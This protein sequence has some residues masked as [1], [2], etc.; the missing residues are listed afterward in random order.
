MFRSSSLSIFSASSFISVFFKAINLLLF[1]VLSR[2]P[3]KALISWEAGVLGRSGRQR[4]FASVLHFF[5][6]LFSFTFQVSFFLLCNFDPRKKL[7]GRGLQL[8]R[9][10]SP[11]FPLA[12]TH[13]PF[14]LVYFV[15]LASFRY[16]SFPIVLIKALI[17]WMSSALQHIRMATHHYTNFTFSTTLPFSFRRWQFLFILFFFYRVLLILVESSDLLKLHSLKKINLSFVRPSFLSFPFCSVSS[18]YCLT[19]IL[20]FWHSSKSPHFTWGPQPE[21][22]TQRFLTLI[23][24]FSSSSL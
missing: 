14:L 10:K 21:A 19:F 13:P 22:E 2:Y 16:F 5:V 4:S 17:S 8:K 12:L 18:Y 1:T 24:P 9:S 23:L 3:W 11:C 7:R 20:F 6:H 15:L